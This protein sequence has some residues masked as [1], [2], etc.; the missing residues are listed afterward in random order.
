MNNYKVFQIVTHYKDG[1][2]VKGNILM[3]DDD[4]LKEFKIAS[5]ALLK[6]YDIARVDLICTYTAL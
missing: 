1:R 4:A 2:K 5:D 3:I 6:D